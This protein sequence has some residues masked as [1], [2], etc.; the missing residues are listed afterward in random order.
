MKTNRLYLV[1][2][3]GALSTCVV[4]GQQAQRSTP[5]NPHPIL[6]PTTSNTPD[7]HRNLEKAP[8]ARLAVIRAAVP[9]NVISAT[10]PEATASLCG[11]LPVPLD[12]QHPTGATINI[13]FELYPH[14]NSGAA[15]S[16]ILAN[17][18]G[19]GITTSGERDFAQF[20]FAS[21]MDVHDLLLID[22]R[23]RGL[24]GAIDCPAIQHGTAPF[25]PSEIDCAAQLGNAASRYGSGDIAEDMDAVRAAL[26]YDKVDYFGASYGGADVTA[27]ATR[28][29]KHLRSVVLD[30]PIGQPTVN[31]LVRLRDR[32]H[33]DPRMVRLDCLRSV[34][35]S[36]DQPN[37]DATLAELIETIQRHP[38]EGDS[39]DASGNPV[40]VRID[41]N[42]LLNF[43]IT[44]PTFDFSNTGEILAAARALQHGDEVPLLRLGAEGFFTLRGDYGD[45]TFNSAGSFYATGCSD[46]AQ[47][48]DWD[49]SYDRRKQD[50]EQAIAALPNNYFAPF[51]KDAPTDI[52][53]S[54]LG[55]QC[56]W[57]QEP[58]RPSPMA[59]S[60]ASY[61][62][63]PTLVLDGDIDNRVPLEATEPVA[64]LFPNSRFVKVAEA[65]HYTVSFSQCA[66]TLAARFIEDLHA[67]DTSCASGPTVLFPAVGR[68]PLFVRQARPAKVDPA[69]TN[70]IGVTER[71][72]VSVAVATAIDA[73]QR[74]LS[75]SGSGVGLRGGTFATVFGA[76]TATTLTNCAFASDVV[77]NGSLVWAADNSLTADLTVGGPGTAGGT[78]HVSGFWQV[79]GPVG[80]FTVSGTLGGK[81]VAVLVPEA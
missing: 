44:Y 72:T 8:T 43:V 32:T 7:S 4:W 52:L 45:P 73:L 5:I 68:F 39:Y 80:N 78:L 16:A 1:L 67:G 18:G 63:T 42:G 77:V 75:G 54:T 40:H 60:H 12:R 66:Q 71:R 79:P 74:S 37:P 21:D 36:A 6:F 28:F 24:S 11:Y 2:G 34:L 35:C 25:A 41:E 14:T 47:P 70:A 62:H 27:Y 19:P 46:A 23:G 38:I 3:L 13:Y 10:C 61:P 20:L 26:G 81:A 55:K 50:Y 22:D 59:P 33:S 9:P 65:G 48:W 69:G 51:S 30:A 31:E 15:Q 64:D 76:D 29:G 57:W 58:T 53:F 56:L 49:D 17:F